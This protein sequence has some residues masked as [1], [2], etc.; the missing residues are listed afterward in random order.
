MVFGQTSLFWGVQFSYPQIFMDSGDPKKV[1]G[2]F[3]N[4]SLF[5]EIRRWARDETR[6]TPFLF[7]GE[8]INVPIR[9]GK[10]CFSWINRHPQLLQYNLGVADAG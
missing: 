2:S 4:T 1:D 6:A 9:L 7:Q 10:N 3:A 8:R 5:Q